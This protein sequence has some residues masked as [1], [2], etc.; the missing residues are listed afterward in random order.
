MG[1][2]GGEGRAI[3]VGEYDGIEV[4]GLGGLASAGEVD[5]SYRF[6]VILLCVRAEW[7]HER[8]EGKFFPFALYRSFLA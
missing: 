6:Q 8:T 2:G 3:V 4:R 5:V 1:F 7:L